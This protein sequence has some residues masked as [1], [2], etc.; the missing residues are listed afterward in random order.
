MA[1]S[2][3]SVRLE[4]VMPPDGDDC[5]MWQLRDDPPVYLSA[6]IGKEEYFALGPAYQHPFVTGIFNIAGVTEAAVTAHRVSVMKS[7]AF[8]WTEVNTDLGNYLLTQFNYTQIEYLG[9]SANIDGTGFR[10]D[11]S[12]RRPL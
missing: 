10:V 5:V 6:M 12:N 2:Q 3:L 8:H 11:A 4:Y 9:G 1:V 7:P